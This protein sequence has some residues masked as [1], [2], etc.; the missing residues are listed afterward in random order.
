MPHFQ[1]LGAS[2]MDILS[3]VFAASWLVILGVGCQ[4]TPTDRSAPGSYN[5]SGMLGADGETTAVGVT[6]SDGSKGFAIACRTADYCL[7][8]AADIC[9]PG[10]P[11]IVSSQNAGTENN[12]YAGG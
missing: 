11:S 5:Y 2:R 1:A 3:R 7:R 12:A 6:V 8:R 10:T 4:A 9:A